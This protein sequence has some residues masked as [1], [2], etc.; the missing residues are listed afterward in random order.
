[1]G[2]GMLRKVILS[3]LSV[4]MNYEIREI[5]CSSGSRSISPFPHQNG[6]L[7]EK[8][9]HLHPVMKCAEEMKNALLYPMC[10]YYIIT[11][12]KMFH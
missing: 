7:S 12:L 10:M 9:Q 3:K 6:M 1:M 8:L 5:G 4:A 11:P 2:K